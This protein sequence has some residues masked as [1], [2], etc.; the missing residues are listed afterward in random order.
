M[1]VQS[2][3][4]VSVRFIGVDTAERGQPYF[5]EPTGYAT[6]ELS[7]KTIYLEKDVSEVDQFQRLLRYIWLA[8]P[9][10]G[11]EAEVRA[12]MSNARLLLEGH[13][14]LATF[15]PDVKYV[16][17]FIKFQEEARNAQK[18]AWAPA[19]SPAQTQAQTGQKCDP[20]YPDVCIPSPPPD[21]DCGDIPHRRFRVLPLDPHNFD[22][23]DNDGIGCESW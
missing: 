14:R 1:S 5:D 7:G 13:G 17:M 9:T 2:A 15:P 3:V 10:I 4:P 20:A 8:R 19:P 18:G 11:N 12:S 16:D 22:G 21:L 23:N 6:A